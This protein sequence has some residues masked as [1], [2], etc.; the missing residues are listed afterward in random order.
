MNCL[1][2]YR[3]KLIREINQ[4]LRSIRTQPEEEAIHEYRVGVKRLT[5]FYF[6][7]SQIDP[8]LQAKTILKPYR[9]SFKFVGKIRDGHIAINLIRNLTELD[10]AEKKGL[11]KAINARVRKDIR[12]F[13]KH[14]QSETQSP[15]RMPSV[16]TLG[17]SER[18]ILK[19]KPIILNALISSVSNT[20]GRVTAKQW[21]KKRILLK[22]YQHIMDAF[23]YCPGHQSDERELKQIYMLQ[24]LLGDWH[25]RVVTMELLQSMPEIEHQIEHIIAVA[26]NQDRLL[27]GS[28]KIYLHNYSIWY[29]TTKDSG[30]G[31]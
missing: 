23:E 22:R 4:N 30:G 7:L 11:I 31:Q 6:F 12:A 24:K 19:H 17:I 29:K 25:D 10:P 20:E 18:A 21:H 14:V 13:A 1:D 16:K 8:S 9:T 3:N 15:I 26:Q 2:K 27:L 5:A 28:A